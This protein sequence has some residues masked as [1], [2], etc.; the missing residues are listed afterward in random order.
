[1]TSTMRFDRWEN[2]LQNASVT[3]DQVSGGSALVPVIPTSVSVGAGTASV[4]ANGLITV[5][6]AYDIKINGVF[7]SLY[8][9]YLLLVNYNSVT[10]TPSI[11]IKMSTSGTPNSSGYAYSTWRVTSSGSGVYMS[12]PSTTSGFYITEADVS[13]SSGA[14]RSEVTI[15][16]PFETNHTIVNVHG[17]GGYAAQGYNMI[18]SSGIHD[19]VSRDGF[20]LTHGTS[21]ATGTVQIYGY[22]N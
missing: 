8:K 9:N 3:M 17:Q 21:L 10:T 22:R 20:Q 12:S 18:L 1:M 11:F 6:S 14:C 13:Q 19:N 4:G 16:S 7:S 5:T 2:T 15:F